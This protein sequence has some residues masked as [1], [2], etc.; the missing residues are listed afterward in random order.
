MSMH[1]RAKFTEAR[2]RCGHGQHPLD[3]RRKVCAAIA[4]LL[5]V[6]AWSA[7]PPWVNDQT[8]Q[9][10]LAAG[11]V[12]VRVVFENDDAR[13]RV[14]AAVA[15]HANPETVWNVLTD[16]DHAAT[17]IPGVKRCRRVQSAPDGSWDIVEHEAKYSWLMPAITCVIR[18]DYKRPQRIDF[19]RIS[20]DLKEEDGHWM[21]EDPAPRSSTGEATVVEYELHVEPGFWIPRILL[22]HSLRT[23]LPA[24]LKAVRA[25]SESIASRQASAEIAA[26]PVKQ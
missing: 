15:I 4:M 18:A 2:S 14:D 11:Q 6:A 24:V 7:P 20:G 5:P 19:K 22:R 13:M 9:Q 3:P 25:R 16:C 26:A 17:F 10:E 8:V 23:E 21:L 12:A 1:C